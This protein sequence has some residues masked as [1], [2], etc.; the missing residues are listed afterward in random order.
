MLFKWSKSYFC[1][2]ENVVYGEINERIPGLMIPN[3]TEIL[4]KQYRRS[5]I[6]TQREHP[7]KNGQCFAADILSDLF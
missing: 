2:I 7:K 4:T 1:K 5:D 6:N 3:F